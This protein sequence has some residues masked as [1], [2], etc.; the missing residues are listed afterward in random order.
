MKIVV[1]SKAVNVVRGLPVALAT[2][3][4]CD[5]PQILDG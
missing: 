2:S 4:S 5:R 3:V 1:P